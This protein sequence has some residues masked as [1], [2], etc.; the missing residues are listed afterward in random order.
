MNLFEN[1]SEICYDNSILFFQF[2]N[3][4]IDEKTVT[5]MCFR[6]ALKSL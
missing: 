6:I 2:K 3:V 1:I 4:R 5:G